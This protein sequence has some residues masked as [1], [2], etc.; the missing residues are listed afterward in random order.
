MFFLLMR[1]ILLELEVRPVTSG[2]ILIDVTLI[3]LSYM[4]TQHIFH[5]SLEYADKTEVPS[6]K[7][8]ADV[9]YPP[10]GLNLPCPVICWTHYHRI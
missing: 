1:L 8:M 2:R 5:F 7:D 10:R 3:P 6:L 9:V 4:H